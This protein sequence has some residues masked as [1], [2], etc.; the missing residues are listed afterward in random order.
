MEVAE[1]RSVDA[2]EGVTGRARDSDCDRGESGKEN[3]DV[4]D[5]P[6]ERESIR[7]GT[8]DIE[9]GPDVGRFS[10]ECFEIWSVL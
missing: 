1:S 6:G 5:C 3:R 7:V 2:R 4:D 8:A 9:L 10:V